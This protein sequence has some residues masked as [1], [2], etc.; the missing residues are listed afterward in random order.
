MMRVRFLSVALCGLLSG[1]VTT[2][3]QDRAT[4]LNIAMVQYDH[5]INGGVLIEALDGFEYIKP[6]PRYRRFLR[7][8]CDRIWIR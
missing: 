5:P 8:S 4:D 1:C 7:Q 3:N 2:Y 6:Y